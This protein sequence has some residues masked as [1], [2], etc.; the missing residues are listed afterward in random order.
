[1]PWNSIQGGRWDTFL[2]RLFS[3]K[4]GQISP[5]IA[6]DITPIMVVQEFQPELHF[7]RGERL[8]AVTDTLPGS[9]GGTFNTLQLE[10]PLG[11]GLLITI[12]GYSVFAGATDRT[13]DSF[14]TPAVA[15]AGA[16]DPIARDSRLDAIRPGADPTTGA[17]AAAITV[18]RRTGNY[19]NLAGTSHIQTVPHILLPGLAFAI[20]VRTA[21]QSGDFYIFWRERVFEPSELD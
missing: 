10:N 14:I 2:R 16:A 20:Q 5:S 8:Y 11:S 15:L 7:L 13:W 4:Q 6:G 3:I 17:A 18:T 1:M 9:G 21:T 19:T 12:L